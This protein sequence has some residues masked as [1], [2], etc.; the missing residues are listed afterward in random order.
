VPSRTST[1]EIVC[2]EATTDPRHGIG[3]KAVAGGDSRVAGIA[4]TCKC[5]AHLRARADFRLVLRKCNC[6]NQRNDTAHRSNYM[7]HGVP[8]RDA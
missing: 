5:S 8:L 3:R 2:A 4:I 1:E 6:S 7:F